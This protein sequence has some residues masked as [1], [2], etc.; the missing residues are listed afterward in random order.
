[1]TFR[2]RGLLIPTSGKCQKLEFVPDLRNYWDFV[3]G[4]VQ[5]IELRDA[6]IYAAEEGK[7]MRLPINDR[8]TSL[9]WEHGPGMDRVPLI[10]RDYIVG[11][12][13]LVGSDGEI[14]VDLPDYYYD[15]LQL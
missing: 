8:A 5:I 3:G 12:V 6:V 4:Y 13:V 9:W 10:N 1:M 11:T 2:V 7:L 15:G 14:D